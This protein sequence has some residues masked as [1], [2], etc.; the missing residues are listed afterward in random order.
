MVSR[1][2]GVSAVSMA[3][4]VLA[5]WFRSPNDEMLRI[6]AVSA[7]LSALETPYETASDSHHQM[8]PE[9]VRPRAR[10]AVAY[11]ACQDLFAEAL[12]LLDHEALDGEP[13]HF[14]TISSTNEL[15]KSFAHYF[16]HG[17]AAEYDFILNFVLKL[18]CHKIDLFIIFFHNFKYK[19]I[20]IVD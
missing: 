9:D 15:L 8:S 4:A 20:Q 10:V 19:S 3:V 12:P 14:D 1:A 18:N 16:R 6:V 7:G 5:W 2:V 13:Q 17:A 11:G